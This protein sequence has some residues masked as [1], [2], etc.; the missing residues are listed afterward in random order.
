MKFITDNGSSVVNSESF[1]VLSESP[2]LMKEVV[3]ASFQLI[4]T[5]KRKRYE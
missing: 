5:L 3:E 4:D 2:I 1:S